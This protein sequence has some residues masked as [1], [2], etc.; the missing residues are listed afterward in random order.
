MVIGTTT[1]ILLIRLHLL[2][3]NTHNHHVISYAKCAILFIIRSEK[4]LLRL[5]HW[6]CNIECC[7]IRAVIFKA[8][9]SFLVII[10]IIF[11]VLSIQQQ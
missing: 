4:E 5:Q 6:S 2:I 9:F 8:F 7:M 1:L 10:A 11:M 3:I